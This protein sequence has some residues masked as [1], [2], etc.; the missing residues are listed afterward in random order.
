MILTFIYDFFCNQFLV[1]FWFQDTNSWFFWNNKKWG[2]CVRYFGGVR[3]WKFV[4]TT[5]SSRWRHLTKGG[6]TTT[7]CLFTKPQPLCMTDR[8]NG[9]FLY[10]PLPHTPHTF[11]SYLEYRLRYIVLRIGA[12]VTQ[13]NSFR[14]FVLI[15]LR[16]CESSD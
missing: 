11:R 7:T 4:A 5:H 9:T 6:R 8:Q 13:R 14:F 10:P 15:F 16:K 1:K 2:I 12:R 3:K